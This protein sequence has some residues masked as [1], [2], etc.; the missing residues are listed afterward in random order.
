M[1]A[2]DRS[3]DGILVK[4]KIFTCHWPTARVFAIY[5][6]FKQLIFVE[7]EKMHLHTFNTRSSRASGPC[8]MQTHFIFC[9][10]ACVTF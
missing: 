7:S 1:V 6:N 3:T 5:H 4:T 8:Q 9:C 2:F 10:C